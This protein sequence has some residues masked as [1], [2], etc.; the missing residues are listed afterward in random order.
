MET[1][2]LQQWK[3][4]QAVNGSNLIIKYVTE[5]SSMMIS[6][7]IADV[8]T[9]CGLGYPPLPFTNNDAEG[10]KE[11]IKEQTR[12]RQSGELDFIQNIRQ[13]AKRLNV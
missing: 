8:T 12:H 13:M 7:M 5:H 6:H 1:A 10:M 2:Y 4:S 9:K 11:H 3:N